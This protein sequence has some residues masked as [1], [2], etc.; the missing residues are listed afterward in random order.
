MSAKG[1]NWKVFWNNL[2]QSR[3][4]LLNVASIEQNAYARLARVVA[5][6]TRGAIAL[7]LAEKNVYENFVSSVRRSVLQWR[8]V[9]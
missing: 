6:G 8:C 3:H 2:K 4:N 9:N 5:Y 1:G 7:G